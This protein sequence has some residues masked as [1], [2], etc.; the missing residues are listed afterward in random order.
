M[1]AFTM[2]KQP[3]ALPVLGHALKLWFHPLEFMQQLR[4]CGDIAVIRLGTS[5]AYVVNHPDLIRQMLVKDVTKFDKGVQF[6]K[7][8]PFTGNGLFNSHGEF[9]L[10]Q[11]RLMQ[12]AF[13]RA[14]IAEYVR[15]MQELAQARIGSWAS[16]QRLEM[17]DQLAAL[18]LAIVAKALCSTDI[19]DRAA[20][21]F[22]RSLPIVLD[23]IGKRVLDPTGLMEKMPL[24][25]NIRFDRA[26]SSMHKV[27]DD[28]ITSY[29]TH[30]GDQSD[31]LSMMLLAH[32]QET[33]ASMTD[34]QVH[35]EVISILAAGAETTA[36]TLTWACC[37]IGERP[38]V[39]RR[40]RA[41][42]DLVAGDRAIEAA[43]IEK[44]EY[45]RRVIT[46]TL[47]IFPTTWILTRRPREDTELGGQKIPAGA[48]VLFSLYALHR[49]PTYYAEPDLFDP[50]RWLPER[51]KRV[52]RTAYL[53]F[54]AGVRGCIGEQFAW[55]ESITILATLVR[56][57]QVR[58]A[59]DKKIKPLAKALLL[60]DRLS[61][62]V[63]ERSPITP[64]PTHR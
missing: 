27:V 52:P 15:M 1:V 19:G 43:D 26:L 60:P 30:G 57:W 36:D 54:G 49:D 46:E 7:L 5:N 9:H 44:L 62:I 28:V 22:A 17:N 61:M 55:T 48:M 41:E 37:L 35:D 3:S 53:P 14:R 4:A 58:L 59:D 10:R 51:A 40:M 31:L 11:R 45:T 18:T 2:N 6:D 20:Q 29:R 24:P 47:R 56:H 13:H 25:S 32:D 8:I 23:G 39:Q 33:N 12:P 16:G 63:E 64:G 50:D 38:E 34:E 21:E 42:I